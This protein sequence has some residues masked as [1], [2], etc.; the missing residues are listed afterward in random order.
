MTTK[1]PRP[2]MLPYHKSWP[3]PCPWSVESCPPWWLPHH[4]PATTTTVTTTATLP[5]VALLCATLVTGLWRPCHVVQQQ[6]TAFIRDG[7]LHGDNLTTTTTTTILVVVRHSNRLPR[8][9]CCLPVPR[10]RKNDCDHGLWPHSMRSWLRIV[11]STHR[12][13]QSQQQ[14]CR[15][16]KALPLPPSAK[17]EQQSPQK[18]TRDQQWQVV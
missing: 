1:H 13:R 3:D 4:P 15:W 8:Q 18:P 9:H 17:H 10:K 11:V 7:S 14:Q 2:I 16:Q 6:R 12:E 5:R